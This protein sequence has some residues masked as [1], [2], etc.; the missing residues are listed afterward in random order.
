M[1]ID[2]F[3]RAI[4]G[5]AD[6]V[7]PSR[8]E[9]GFRVASFSRKGVFQE[10]LIAQVAMIGLPAIAVLNPAKFRRPSFMA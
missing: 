8:G 5:M 2:W 9:G 4:D 7:Y 1:G 6:H 10:S 3:S